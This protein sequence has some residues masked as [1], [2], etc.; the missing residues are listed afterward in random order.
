GDYAIEPGTAIAMSILL[1]HHRE[2]VYPDPFS[3]R[4]E[5]WLGR[6]PG[7]YDWIPFGGG[8][9]RCLGAA[10]AM[11]EQRVVLTTMARRLDL[12]AP[13]PAPERAMHRNVTMIPAQGA[14]VVIAKKH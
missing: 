10:L 4:P 5:R 14:T 11:A 9:R 2:D 3:F 13:T 8:I 12:E 7:T 1:V 6:K